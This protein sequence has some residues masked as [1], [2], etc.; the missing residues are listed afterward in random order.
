MERRTF[1]KIIT[2]GVA[3]GLVDP[4]LAGEPKTSV[5]AGGKFV[6]GHRGAC[7]YAPENTLES[8]RLAIE[9]RADYVEQDLQITKD[10]VLV[11]CHDTSLE[12]ISNAR[13]VFPDRFKEETVKGQKIKRWYFH[14]FTLKEIKQ[15]DAGAW[16]RSE[17]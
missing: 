5:K 8:Y 13:D 15:L 11:C 2:S 7:A 9:Q 17:E 1:L 3:A 6:V 16:F 4:S 14:E 12:R 10:G